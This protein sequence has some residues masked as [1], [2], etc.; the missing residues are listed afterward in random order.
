MSTLTLDML[1]EML[2]KARQAM[3]DCPMPVAIWLGPRD[4]TKLLALTIGDEAPSMSAVPIH[5]C[6]ELYPGEAYEVQRGEWHRALLRLPADAQARLLRA[7]AKPK[8]AAVR[9]KP[10]GLAVSRVVTNHDC[11]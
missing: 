9:P 4:N 11:V 2:T 8:P 1:D 3:G 7:L 10:R 6:E 5:V